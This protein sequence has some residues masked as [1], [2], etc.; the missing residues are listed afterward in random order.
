MN[1]PTDLNASNGAGIAYLAM[2][3]NLLLIT[4]AWMPFARELIIDRGVIEI[5][6][7]LALVTRTRLRWGPASSIGPG[8]TK[9]PQTHSE[10]AKSANNIRYGVAW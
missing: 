4:P 5:A 7:S 10:R 2:P 8:H 1:D 9:T 3:A 6:A